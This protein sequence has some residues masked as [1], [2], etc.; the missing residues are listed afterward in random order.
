MERGTRRVR[1]VGFSTPPL[2]RA[3]G[4]GSASLQPL[5]R[6]TDSSRNSGNLHRMTDVKRSNSLLPV[7]ASVP[8]VIRI[9]PDTAAGA[10]A[11]DRASPATAR[12]LNSS[13]QVEPRPAP[14]PHDDWPAPRPCASRLVEG[15]AAPLSDS[16]W[17]GATSPTTPHSERLAPCQAR[18]A[19]DWPRSLSRK[20]TGAHLLQVRA[21]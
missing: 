7:L 13:S 15:A 8:M 21:P 6:P 16:P 5:T 19:S 12:G 10:R 11:I 20:E 1:L 9:P 17:P 2:P 4:V 3:R 14:P 18:A